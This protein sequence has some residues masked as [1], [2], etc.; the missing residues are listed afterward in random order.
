VIKGKN[1][2]RRWVLDADL[3]GPFDRI[4]HHHIMAM[5][6]S[7]PARGM[8]RQWLKAGVFEDGQLHRKG[9]VSGSLSRR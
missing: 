1:P 2:S 9:L 7:F 5:I 4:S 3:A 6:G 8:I